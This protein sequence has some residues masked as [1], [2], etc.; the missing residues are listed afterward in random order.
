MNCLN[1]FSKSHSK[2]SNENNEVSLA[3]V[4]ESD[5]RRHWL[6]LTKREFKLMGFAGAGF[7]LD[8]YDL[9]IINLVSPIYE[10]LYWGGLKGKKPHY[11]SG[12]HGLVNAAANIGN[13]F[14]QILFGFMGDFFGRKFVYGKEMIVVIIA[15]ILV[16]ALPKSIP[17]PLGKMMWIFAWRWLLGLGIGGDYPMSATITSE[18]S[19]LSRRGTLLSIVF[20]FQ[21]FGTLAGAIVTIILLACFEKPLNQRGEYTKLEGVWRLQMGLALVPALLVLIPRLTMKESKSYEQSKALNKYTDNDTYIADDDEPKK[22]NQNV[23]EEK[24]INLT[25][26]SDSHPTSTEYFGDKRASTVPTSENTSGFIEYFSQW[27]HF[28]HLLATAVSWFLLDIAFYGVN[29]NQSVI[30]KAIG[31]S[32]GKN[33]YH[34]LMRG[35]IGNLIIAI[36][37]YVPGYWFTVFLVEK[38]GR[39][40]IQLQGLFITGLMF[41]ILAGSWDTISTGGRFACFVIAQFFSNFGPNAT[42]FLYPAEVFPARVRGTAHGLSA[43]LG[44]CGAILASLLFNFLTSVIGYGNVMWIFCGCM[45]GA[46]FFTL[47]L[48]ETKMRDADEIDREEVLRGGNGKT[49]QGRWSWYFNGIF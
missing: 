22:D 37:G 33:E 45:W 17:T 43:A 38:L 13:V 35:A 5:T 9:F 41:A 39:K 23:V 27:H 30:L 19:L 26:S 11:P 24:Q 18:R 25:T 32:S 15:T 20:S 40:W 2:N 29:L 46:I 44:K 47:L 16:I 48:P 1:P 28:K 3:D 14:G 6:G 49:H 7:F 12:I 8:S 42:T 21:G 31:F 4:A 36:A 10:Y 34:T